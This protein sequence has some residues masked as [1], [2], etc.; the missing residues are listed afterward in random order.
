M[1][2]PPIDPVLADL[3]AAAE[4]IWEACSPRWPDLSLD[5]L[6]E[7][8]STNTELMERGRRGQ[9]WPTALVAA[10]QT[11]GRGRRGRSWTAHPGDTLTFSL[12]LPLQLGG[13]P[14]GGSAL[15][16]AVGLSLA[17]SL[18]RALQA[19]HASGLGTAL[20]PIG[21]KWPNDLWLGSRKLGGILI[22]ATPAPGLPSGPDGKDDTDGSR[23]V[24]IGVGINVR[25]GQAPAGSAWLSRNADDPLGVGQA[26]SWILPDLLDTVHRF[27]ATG[28]A[29][30][31]TAWSDRDVLKGQ[32]VSLWTRPGH[33]PDAQ[34]PPDASGTAQGV[35]ES[36]ALLVHTAGGLQRWSSGEVSVRPALA[37]PLT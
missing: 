8:G 2:T 14:G 33:M 36:G 22:E 21:L 1:Q 6:P 35:D 34:T 9:T 24:V 26:W 18:D 27:E 37:A 13:V 12:G 5:V 3:N 31:L 11:A 10:S 15:S 17:Q 29:P 16:L 19:R 30:L 20:P 28:F 7:V 25:P 32:E 23:W 4:R